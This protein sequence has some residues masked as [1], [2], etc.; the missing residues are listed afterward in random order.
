MARGS[1][2]VAAWS[3]GQRTVAG[4]VP[5]LDAVITLHGSSYSSLVSI[6]AILRLLIV[7]NSEQYPIHPFGYIIQSSAF[8]CVVQV[9]P[10]EFAVTYV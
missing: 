3:P 7:R 1:R 8:V 10:A 4:N 9:L 5:Y 2:M 6:S